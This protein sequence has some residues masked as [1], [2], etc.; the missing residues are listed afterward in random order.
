MT[1]VTV[2]CLHAQRSRT[3]SLGAVGQVS[4][5]GTHSDN[6]P[7]PAT[8]FLGNHVTMMSSAAAQ[9]YRVVDGVAS[10]Q[11]ARL[12]GRTAG[13]GPRRRHSRPACVER[14]LLFPPNTLARTHA[15]TRTHTYT[16]TCARPSLNAPSARQEMCTGRSCLRMILAINVK[17]R[18]AQCPSTGAGEG[19]H[20][21]ADRRHTIC[22][23]APPVTFAQVQCIFSPK[24]PTPPPPQTPG[25]RSASAFG[26]P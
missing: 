21:N 7:R 19:R 13:L 10:P 18:R 6:L 14:R 8:V 4:Q 9:G 22:M 2:H 25:R 5:T 16:H 23:T 1:G 3:S 12:P 26:T 11:P 15:R 24:P 20:G 17:T